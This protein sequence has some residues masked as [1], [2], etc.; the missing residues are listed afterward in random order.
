MSVEQ[1]RRYGAVAAALA[2]VG[3]AGLV[4]LAAAPEAMLRAGHFVL[5]PLPDAWRLTVM[6]FV[7]SVIGPMKFVLNPARVG[8]GLLLTLA[9]WTCTAVSTW[10][11]SLGF[12]LHLSISAV[13]VVQV[14]ISLA[15][16]LPQAPSF[17]GMFQAGAMTA[18]LFY[19]IPTG[20]AA[21]FANVL[22]AVNVVPV[23]VA[24]LIVLHAEG[25]SLRSLA[26]QSEEAAEHLEGDQSTEEL[27]P[28]P[29]PQDGRRG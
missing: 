9:V 15:V 28:P 24:G 2:L 23:T 10:L 21:A 12:D 17:L 5:A 22:W 6:E 8:L 4:L 19:S 16:M 18:V 14:A 27:A 20:A 3:M 1:I 29:G 7:E 25:L 11:L 13:L 26:Q